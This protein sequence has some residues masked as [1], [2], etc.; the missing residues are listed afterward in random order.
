MLNP[1]LLPKYSTSEQVVGKW[2]DN[3]PIYRKVID[4]GT[5]PNTSTKTVAHNISN[6][7]RIIDYKAVARSNSGTHSVLP[8]P[9]M[10]LTVEYGIYMYFDDTSIVVTTGYGRESYSMY[11]ILEYTKTTD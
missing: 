1:K 2:I 8:I 6:L 4:F 11:V 10:Q 3:K 7:G 9:Y 5:L